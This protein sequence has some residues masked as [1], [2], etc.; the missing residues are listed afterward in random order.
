MTEKHVVAGDQM[1]DLYHRTTPEH[2]AAILHAGRFMTRENTP[3]AFV[4]NRVAGQATGYGAA[5]VHVR[6]R[7]SAA[8]LDDEFPDGEQHFRI[9]L[10]GAQVVDAF[11]VDETG[12]RHPLAP[13]NQRPAAAEAHQALL[14]ARAGFPPTRPST[15]TLR[16]RGPAPL[17]AT[18][19]P[20]PTRDHQRR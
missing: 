12:G 11:T 19:S 4:S 8:E 13:D 5:V 16:D 10:R 9:P 14:D 7:E 3:E 1:I 6:V 18:P 15:G 17:T 20:R 2:A